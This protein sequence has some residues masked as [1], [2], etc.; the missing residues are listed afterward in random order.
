MA[1]RYLSLNK[2]V[3]FVTN[4]LAGALALTIIV[5]GGWGITQLLNQIPGIKL[6]SFTFSAILGLAFGILPMLLG[7]DRDGYLAT[8]HAC[9]LTIAWMLYALLYPFN[10][11]IRWGSRL[12]PLWAA[13]SIIAIFGAFQLTDLYRDRPL[14]EQSITDMAKFL[15]EHPRMD[16]PADQ[17]VRLLLVG[18]TPLKNSA[19]DLYPHLHDFTWG[20]EQLYLN[21]AG[22]FE[23]ARAQ[24][25]VTR[26]EEAEGKQGKD[27]KRIDVFLTDLLLM[28]L[29]V[30]LSQQGK[31]MPFT[32]KALLLQ[33]QMSSQKW[34]RE[35]SSLD[36]AYSTL[37]DLK[38]NLIA[39]T[40]RHCA[41][42]YA[43]Y[44]S[45]ST[46]MNRQDKLRQKKALLDE[47]ERL[48]EKQAQSR[49]SSGLSHS[50]AVNNLAGLVT[51]R[52]QP[53]L[54]KLAA[55]N[56]RVS[57]MEAESLMS[58]EERLQQQRGLLAGTLRSSAKS[59][60]MITLADVDLQLAQVNAL[61][62]DFSK[63]RGATD[64]E[65]LKEVH[66]YLRLATEDLLMAA[67]CGFGA[68]KF[69]ANPHDLGLCR[70]LSFNLQPARYSPE[71]NE[72]FSAAQAN[73][74][75]GLGE[76]GVKFSCPF[77]L[78]QNKLIGAVES[79]TT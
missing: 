24:E 48:W 1:G 23:E 53:D 65:R 5:P 17:Q 40:N 61:S 67:R 41:N 63:L 3:E 4:V 10:L 46:K 44:E 77:C 8:W 12:A 58:M 68:E 28:R 62:Y 69:N 27:P 66:R 39:L 13:L 19:E 11:W 36:Q 64:L 7:K 75:E 50:R 22:T 73:A 30:H 35:E 55:L 37:N 60:M 45:W 51:D 14:V 72:L 31:V 59:N 76:N 18:Y 16:N 26:L 70:L 2:V 15:N 43:D 56:R 25:V 74:L 20:L 29:Y 21:P 33:E 52:Y 49:T 32:Y 34:A 38:S 79:P 47:A 71:V 78:E 57:R 6:P 9:R 54:E 42:R